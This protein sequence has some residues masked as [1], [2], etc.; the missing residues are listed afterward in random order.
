MNDNRKVA[1][2]RVGKQELER[3]MSDFGNQMDERIYEEDFMLDQDD[4]SEDDS[5]SMPD[6]RSK[7]KNSL[8]KEKSERNIDVLNDFPEVREFRVENTRGLL[9]EDRKQP[10]KFRTM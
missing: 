7:G 8:G 3:Q 4:R 1:M 6:S 10:L 9:E 2:T 5:G